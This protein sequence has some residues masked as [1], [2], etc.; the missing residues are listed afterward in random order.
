[1]T[2]SQTRCRCF[3]KS[4]LFFLFA[5]YPGQKSF[6]FAKVFF[7]QP[8]NHLPSHP[9]LNN[10]YINNIRR[11][12]RSSSAAI[13]RTQGRRTILSIG[14]FVVLPP[15]NNFPPPSSP[16]YEYVRISAKGGRSF[17]S[18]CAHDPANGAE[19]RNSPVKNSPLK[20]APA[21][22]RRNNARPTAC[23]KRACVRPS[24]RLF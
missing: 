9:E 17:V 24:V 3:E 5:N 6:F 11:G 18:A 22:E 19:I 14:P 21:A 13:L 2:T 8:T 4:V 10:E 23:E 16:M 12:Q 20:I 1:M 7:R 15:Q